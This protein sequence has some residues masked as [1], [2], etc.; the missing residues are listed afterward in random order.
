MTSSA[1]AGVDWAG[2][3]WLVVRFRDGSYDTCRVEPDFETLWQEHDDLDRIL[4]DVPIGLPDGET[5][6][7]R[8]RVDSMARSVTGFSSSVFPVPSRGAAAGAHEEAE[9]D[10]TVAQQNQDDIDKGLT[11]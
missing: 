1:V 11:Q 7:Q 6:V 4:I 5:L 10:E 2:G 9:Y 8:E 3:E